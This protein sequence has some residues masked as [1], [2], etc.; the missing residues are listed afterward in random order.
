MT[1]TV[2]GKLVKQGCQMAYFQTKNHNFGKY[3]EG[4]AMKDEYLLGILSTLRLFGIFCDHLVHF[5]LIWFIIF[6][7]W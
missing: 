3:M 1:A 4:L 6:N 2:Q 7:F 5:V